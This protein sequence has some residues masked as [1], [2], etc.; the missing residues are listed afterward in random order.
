MFFLW[1]DF[2]LNWHAVITY[3]FCVQSIHFTHYR[4]TSNISCTLVGNKF[5]DHSDVV[6]A[7]P[8][9]PAP[10]T[11]SFSTK[12]LA[13]VDWAKTSAQRGEK[14]LSC[15]IWCSLYQRFDGNIYCIIPAVHNHL[16]IKWMNKP[17]FLIH[18]TAW[19]YQMFSTKLWY[20]HC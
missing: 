2:V 9:G 7:S 18:F 5:V 4:W 10:T 15:G 6:W 11:S 1:W 20:P 14:N 12:R 16:Q 13:A 3:Q 19:I 8:V 17:S